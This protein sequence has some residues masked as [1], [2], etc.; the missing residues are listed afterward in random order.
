MN[1][2]NGEKKDIKKAISLRLK[3]AGAV[4]VRVAKAQELP[5]SE[6]LLFHRWLEK[7]RNA[8][9]DYL[10]R[11]EQLRN[12]PETLLENVRS[13]V[14][15]AF[16]FPKAPEKSDIAAY[17]LGN[18]YHDVLRKILR[19]VAREIEQTYNCH[20]RICID[21]A[22]LAERSF[23]LSCGM[24]RRGRNGMIRIPGYGSRIFLAELLL[25]IELPPDPPQPETDCGDCGDC[26]ACVNACPT[27]AL[28]AEGLVDARKCLSYLTIE[29][30]GNWTESQ[31]K[32]MLTK[33]GRS[34]L[35]GC[36][37]CLKACGFN[38]LGEAT[39]SENILPELL[40]RP[41]IVNLT[42]DDVIAMTQT[43]FSAMF[44]K[45]PIKR[46][47][48]E[49]LRRN[50]FNVKGY[51][52]T[53]R[54]APS[55]TGRMHLG[56]VLAALLSWLDVKSVGGN[57]IVRYEDL[58]PDRSKPEYANLIDGDLRWL[59]LIADNKEIITD[60]GN[61]SPRQSER[62]ELYAQALTE[63]IET[64]RVY[65]CTCRR[66]DIM[67]TQAPHQSDGRIVYAGTCRPQSLGGTAPDHCS[68][69]LDAKKALRICVT[70]ENINFEDT[71]F[72][73]QSVN[74]ATHCG[75]FVLRRADGAWA[76]Q[77][78]V[79]VDDADMRVTRIV[80]GNDLLLS[81]A[82]QIFLYGLLKKPVPL[83]MHI[84]LLCTHDG[85]RL[86]KRDKDLDMESLRCRFKADELL[87]KL[88]KLAGLTHDYAPITPHRLLT[89]FSAHRQ[90]IIKNLNV[91]AI[92]VDTAEFLAK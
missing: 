68:N 44:S 77:L 23:S 5:E 75:D 19:P 27:G 45:S 60:S 11:N 85:R 20:T 3:Q 36:D 12:S 54:F 63:L 86:S 25:D 4:R 58:D 62:T 84:P 55:P 87:G 30:K 61:L 33:A 79:V 31:Q 83:Y 90:E 89:I 34:T 41:T 2:N 10:K 39:T 53:G 59:G 17:A 6:Q 13:V 72:G 21:S 22:P 73:V 82:Q 7:G 14:C 64:G 71:V 42:A 46:T 37:I 35:F 1:I 51:K 56:N 38:N 48:L 66:A 26:N 24:G 81:T 16:P 18:D 80:R 15:M 65:P 8:G 28:S 91:N 32:F 70:D 50:A 78:A 47:R 67:A 57:W 43:T 40:P 76:Y 49:G 74:L 92:N 69:M 9:M 88:A 52:E 29:H